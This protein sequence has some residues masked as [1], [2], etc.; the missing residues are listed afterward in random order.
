MTAVLPLLGLLLLVP[1]L[2]TAASLAVA[3]TRIEL[4]EDA[5]IGAVTVR[6]EGKQSVLVQAETFRWTAS[7]PE[8]VLEPTRD[9]LAV[10]P[11]FRIAPGGRQTVRVGLREGFPRDVERS[12]RLLL[13]EVAEAQPGAAEGVRFSLRLS[14]PVFVRPRAARP[15]LHWRAH[16]RDRV[17]HVEAENRGSAHVRLGV[18]RLIAGSGR[19]VTL[20]DT[21]GYLLPGERRGWRV[22]DPGFAA[23]G[24]VALVVETQQG[25][26][27]AELLV[28][29]D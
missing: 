27:R 5:R 7:S 24:A 19:V 25:P 10:P 18:V 3:P 6:N 26:S 9:L 21:A 14:L 8:D 20:K 28:E 2:A 4:R 29:E 11:V 23:G 13:T 22:R 12:Y 17:L 16:R 15:E 1:A